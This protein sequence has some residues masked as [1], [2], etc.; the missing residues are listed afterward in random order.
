MS[1]NIFG[2]SGKHASGVNSN[3]GL[4]SV[5]R[6]F[7]QRLIMLSNRLSQKI[8]KSGDTMEGDLKFVYKPDSTCNSLSLGVDGMDRNHSMSLLLGNVRN[9][10]YHANGSPVRLHAEHGFEFKC[11]TGRITKFDHDIILN[12]KHVT[13]LNEPVSSLDAVNKE[14]ADSKLALAENELIRK[15]DLNTASLTNLQ[16]DLLSRIET[17][18]GEINS[19]FDGKI[20][21]LITEQTAMLGKIRLNESTIVALRRETNQLVETTKNSIETE[22]EQR[23]TNIR[24]RQVEIIENFDANRASQNTIR[25]RQTEL[26]SLVD[27]NRSIMDSLVTRVNMSRFIRNN[28]GLIPTLNSSTNKTG[29]NVTASHNA[30][31]AWKVFNSLPGS[32]WT[33]G[34]DIELDGTY[35]EPVY[36]QISL[37]VATRIF[38]IGLRGR[39]DTNRILEWQLRGSND[40]RAGSIIY[41]PEN[42]ILDGTTRYFNVPLNQPKFTHYR[43]VIRKVDSRGSNLVYFQLYS[44]DEVIEM[45]ISDS[46]DSYLEV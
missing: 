38:K 44:L 8:N 2:S 35:T 36:L 9:Q 39:S 34:I 22:N 37:P 13:G 31:T 11:L 30:D 16:T 25:E 20:A 15:I 29:F 6:N 7:N 4:G 21:T 18:R 14:Y 19:Y 23:M 27:V 3:V 26:R 24:S 1:V 5:D 41:N 40:G 46:S 33:A 42:M 12:N 45:S 10:I 28:V 32:F 43:L 17:Q